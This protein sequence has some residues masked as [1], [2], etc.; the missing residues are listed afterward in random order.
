[1]QRFN[2]GSL[3]KPHSFS[4]KSENKT[5]VVSTKNSDIK[6]EESD[7][8]TDITNILTKENSLNQDFSISAPD[9]SIVKNEKPEYQSIG[10]KNLVAK[11]ERSISTESELNISKSSSSS[12]ELV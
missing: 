12:F 2:T 4:K 5:D 10:V 9:L 3:P 7:T 11:I 6:K 8:K 1:M